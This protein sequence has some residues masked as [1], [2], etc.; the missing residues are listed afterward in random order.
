MHKL[1]L[2][3]R[4][5][6]ERILIVRLPSDVDYETQFAEVFR[7]YLDEFSLI[8][9]EA[10]GDA[11]FQELVYSVVLKPSSDPTRFVEAVRGVSQ[12][13]KV[14]LVLGQQEIDL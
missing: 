8:S 2:F 3:A 9:M 13:S 12:N 11:G 7:E 1:G 10:V 14:S 4:V 5:V 6:R